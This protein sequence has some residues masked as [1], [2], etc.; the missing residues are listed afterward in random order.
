[1]CNTGRAERWALPV[2]TNSVRR[3]VMV[4]AI[5]LVSLTGDGLRERIHV[6]F[7][8]RVSI[9]IQRG[10]SKVHALKPGPGG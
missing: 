6:S 2:A 10:E 9:R 8:R 5:G 4:C 1:M 7:R 3:R